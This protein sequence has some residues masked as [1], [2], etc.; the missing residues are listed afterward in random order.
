MAW[1][2]TEDMTRAD[3]FATLA[4][5]QE[6]LNNVDLTGAGDLAVPGEA[7]RAA[8]QAALDLLWDIDQ[9]L[10]RWLAPREG[11]FLERIAF[12]AGVQNANESHV[13]GA[14]R[15]TALRNLIAELRFRR[16]LAFVSEFTKAYNTVG[17]TCAIAV[18][19]ALAAFDAAIGAFA[20]D[21][22]QLLAARSARERLVS[23]GRCLG[24]LPNPADVEAQPPTA[25]RDWIGRC[26]G[27]RW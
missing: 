13:N 20:G 21:P 4:N 8:I 15:E 25:L 10:K 6:Q 5:E 26:L 14:G 1:I 22:A 12:D 7:V 19:D 17:M 18:V 11:A 23:I 2:W 24:V 27:S 3:Y 9:E 16:G